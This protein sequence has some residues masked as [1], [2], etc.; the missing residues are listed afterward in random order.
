MTTNDGSPMAS[1][2]KLTVWTTGPVTTNGGLAGSTMLLH[3]GSGWPVAL[4]DLIRCRDGTVLTMREASVL[5][6]QP[7]VAYLAHECEPLYR[8]TTYTGRS[9]EGTANQALLTR[10]RWKPLSELSP[11]DAVAVVAEY[12]RVFGRGDTDGELLKLLAYLTA[13]GTGCDGT[14]P[15]LEDLEVRADFEA[16]VRAKED[17]CVPLE[18]TDR[19]RLYVRGPAG[20]QSKILRYMDIV[21]VHGVQARDKF[22]PDF[23]FGLRED[24]LRL[25]LNRL[26]TCDGF[27]EASGRVTYRTASIR[28]ARQVQHLLSRFGVVSLLRGIGNDD[29]F[30]VELVINTKPDVLRFIDDIGFLGDQAARAEEVRASLCHLRMIEPPRDRLGPILFDRVYRVDRI[31]PAPVYDLAVQGTHNFIAGDFV[32]RTSSWSSLLADGYLERAERGS[33]IEGFGSAA[34]AATWRPS[35]TQPGKSEGAR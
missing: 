14:A 26:F 33:S 28:M 17:E 29:D 12:P 9:L 20:T 32:V 8:L 21:G 27:V 30:A 24:K 18:D 22:V 34:A 35:D 4:R 13:D 2:K 25:Y 10:E 15:P 6:P 3:A 1:A 19:P 5:L 23:L 31:D 7:P 16:A 11:T